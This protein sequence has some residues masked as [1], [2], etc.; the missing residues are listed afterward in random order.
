MAIL[1]PG[2]RYATHTELTDGIKT[3]FEVNFIGGY[4]NPDDVKAVSYARSKPEIEEGLPND[5]Q[6]HD[7]EI[8]ST[9]GNAATVRIAP[10]IEEGRQLVI[11]R[12]TKKTEMLVQY[13]AGAVL[14]KKNL[15]LANKQLLFLIQEMLDVSGQNTLE[16]N[17]AI[18]T[19]IDLETVIREIYAQVLLLLAANGLISAEPRTWFWTADGDDTDFIMPTADVTYAGLY[20]VYV[21]G[22]GLI[23]DDEY[24]VDIQEDLSQ[25]ALQLVTAPAE[26]S[27]VHAVLR[28][29]ALPYQDTPATL[30]ELR[31]PIVDITGLTYFPELE[32]DR[33]LIRSWNDAAVTVTVK[34]T[35][36][37]A[38]ADKLSTGS[39]Y[40]IQ[41]KG[42][43][44]VTVEWDDGVTV[45]YP[46]DCEPTTRAQ[47]SAITLTCTD[48]ENNVW[49]LTGDLAQA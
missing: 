47:N 6:V 46:D 4:I 36:V 5:R 48:G 7:V 44:Q 31:T 9:S 10:A 27:V 17:E 3:D 39:Y 33:A 13:L 19:V 16:V 1:D 8:I 28:G 12:S 32:C 45:D 2:L 20:D 49:L 22:I 42:G 18:E 41:Q 23:P 35:A 15:D 30:A 25:S 14:G 21:N 40:S 43:G 24:T 11:F 37:G 34:L 26:G 38:E 29:Y